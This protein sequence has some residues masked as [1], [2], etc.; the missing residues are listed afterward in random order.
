MVKKRDKASRK[1]APSSEHAF[2]NVHSGRSPLAALGKIR[3]IN[4]TDGK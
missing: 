3:N 2:G 4:E 1:D